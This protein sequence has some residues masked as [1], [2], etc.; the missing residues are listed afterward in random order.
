MQFIYIFLWINPVQKYKKDF[1][2]AILEGNFL[3]HSGLAAKFFSA[4]SPIYGA[5]YSDFLP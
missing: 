3:I 1:K 2:P 4:A 5:L